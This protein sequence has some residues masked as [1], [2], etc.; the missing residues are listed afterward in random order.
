M[1]ALAEIA[2]EALDW[3]TLSWNKMAKLVVID[4]NL[5]TLVQ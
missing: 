4:N 2:C 5:V 1:Y 3:P